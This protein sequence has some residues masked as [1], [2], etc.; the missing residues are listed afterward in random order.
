MPD[1][2]PR[3]EPRRTSSPAL[4]G[5]VITTLLLSGVVLVGPGDEMAT[6]RRLLGLGPDRYGSAPE[7]TA[8]EGSF[9]FLLTQRGSDAPVGYD[10]CRPVEYAVN[11][12]GGPSD[13]EELIDTAVAHTEWATGLRFVDVGNTTERPFDPRRAGP[14]GGT[15]QPVVVGFA[16]EE[17][18]GGLAG[19]VAGLGG[20][21]ASRDSLGRDYFVTGSIA[22]DTDVFDGPSDGPERENLQ[23]IVDHEFGHVVGL[24]HVSD[25]AELMYESNVGVTE[26]GPGD[27]E[28]MARLGSIPCR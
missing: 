2:P 6:V 7:F 20:S 19:D 14:F 18:I 16:D 8:G 17:E 27:L 15:A 12:G 24:D 26:Y 11:P 9:E 22:L 4:V 28:G 10:P 25:P 1:V 5:I 3:R 23:A 21:V 13:W